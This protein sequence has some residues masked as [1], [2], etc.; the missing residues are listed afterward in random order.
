MEFL[1]PEIAFDG[2]SR[3]KI[4]DLSNLGNLFKDFVDINALSIEWR[5]LPQYFDAKEAQKL[6]SLPIDKM[7]HEISST[8]SFE[9]EIKFPNLGKL[10]KLI[11]SLPH[12]NAEAERIFS[13]VNDVKTKTE[14][15][16]VTKHLTE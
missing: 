12:S 7:W 5:S 6:S 15:D 10:S 14:T 3:S 4:K 2:S 16:L 8:K 11:L 9:D 13:I 1:D